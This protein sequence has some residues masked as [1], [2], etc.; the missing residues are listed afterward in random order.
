MA[1]DMRKAISSMLSPL[2]LVA[3]WFRLLGR[4]LPG[5]GFLDCRA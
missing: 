3:P 4:L 5:L 1:L 2:L